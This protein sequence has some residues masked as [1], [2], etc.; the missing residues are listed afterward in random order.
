MSGIVANTGD[1]SVSKI[2]AAQ[3]GRSEPTGNIAVSGVG[4]K[5]KAHG[6]S[7]HNTGR[8]SQGQ[9]SV[10]QLPALTFS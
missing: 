9:F 2:D 8:P 10:S 5:T 6:V 3:P 4:K 1:G 7:K